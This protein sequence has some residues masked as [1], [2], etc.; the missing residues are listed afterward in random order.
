MFDF[1]SRMELYI[2][3]KTKKKERKVTERG[4]LSSQ[5]VNWVIFFTVCQPIRGYLKPTYF[6]ILRVIY[7]VSEYDFKAYFEDNFSQMLLQLFN[8]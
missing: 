5:A 2:I 7:F 1:R 6:R 4:W 3:R 8:P